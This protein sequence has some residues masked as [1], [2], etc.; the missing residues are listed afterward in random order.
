MRCFSK[1]T[2]KKGIHEGDQGKSIRKLQ[3][4]DARYF[5]QEGSKQQQE[6]AVAILAA[7]QTAKRAI[8]P[9][10]YPTKDSWK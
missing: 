3:R 8:Q 7:G 4:L 2:D 6:Q 9:G 10:V 1:L 5:Q